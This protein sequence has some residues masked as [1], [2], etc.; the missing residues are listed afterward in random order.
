MKLSELPL[1]AQ[2]R[3]GDQAQSIMFSNP[4]WNPEVSRR[5]EKVAQALLAARVEQDEV[6]DDA[7]YLMNL[8]IQEEHR[9]VQEWVEKSEGKGEKA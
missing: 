3:I 6:T 1:P 8:M 2:Y 5:I 9:L 4:K 7:I